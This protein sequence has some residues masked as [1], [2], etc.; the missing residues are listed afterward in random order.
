MGNEFA[1]IT[2]DNRI[3]QKDNTFFKGKELAKVYSDILEEAIRYFLN[4]FSDLEKYVEACLNALKI[5]DTDT[6]RLRIQERLVKEIVNAPAIGDFDQLLGKIHSVDNEGNKQLTVSDDADSINSEESKSDQHGS[7]NKEEDQER[8]GEEDENQDIEISDALTEFVE[9]TSKARELSE[10][11]NWQYTQLEFEN[12]RLKW[13]ELLEA[14]ESVSSEQGYG[15]LLKQRDE[16]EKIFVGR[17]AAFLEKRRERKKDNLDKRAKILDQLQHIIDTKRWHAFKEV[18]HLINR[19]EAIKDVPGD[20]H[21]AEQ[22]KNYQVLLD[23]FNEKKVEYLVRKAQKEEENL[24]GKLAILDKLSSISKSIGP[25]TINWEQMDVEVEELS[26]QWRKIG[27]VPL[28]QADT[29]WEKFKKIR[30]DYDSKKFEY[31]EA[32]QKSVLKN[33]HKKTKLC[34]K[35]EALLEVEDLAVAVREI[36]NI[37]NQWKKI[38][39]IPAEKNNELWERFNG[40]SKKFNEKKNENLDTIRHQEQQNLEK[41]L[42]LCEKAEALKSST[43]W[44]NVSAEMSGLMKSW[45]EIGPVPRRKAGKIWRQFKKAMDT[46]YNNRREHFKNVRQD[47]KENLEKKREILSELEKLVDY[48][49]PEEAVRLAKELQQKFKQIGFVP[50]K[51]KTKLDNDY[52]RVCDLIFQKARGQRS[53]IGEQTRA[54]NG[55]ADDKK[56][57]SSEYFRL[58]KECDKL[59]DEIMRYG[60]TKTF[61]NPGGK[62]NALIDEIQQKIDHA[63]IELDNKLDKLE[64]LR[65]EMET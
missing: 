38:G 1:K 36:N 31:D 55:F 3:I 52:Q 47:Q 6:E 37:H 8:T 23:E 4:M 42:V 57:R 33:I 30:D 44:Q 65:K 13:N 60:D 59:H 5:S 49:D 27:R 24:A 63:Q 14:N 46:F 48:D 53:K 17:K 11:E 50:I 20:N 56:A 51:K 19:W 15:P 64:K 34:E 10:R 26:R 21:A 32:Y 16:A 39:S 2:D 7:E 18:N 54:I 43:D 58:K 61:I 35:A 25:D 41:K 12:I 45:K 9:L 22:E 29:V 62:G 28:E 40:I